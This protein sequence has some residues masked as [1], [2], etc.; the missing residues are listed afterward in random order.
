FKKRVIIVG[1]GSCACCSLIRV[2][3]LLFEDEK[4]GHFSTQK[5]ILMLLQSKQLDSK[6]M[7]AQIA[8]KAI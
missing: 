5:C 2:L 7:T 3:H 1:E 6:K 4:T 8:N